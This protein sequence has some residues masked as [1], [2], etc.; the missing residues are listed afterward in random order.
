[1]YATDAELG[2]NRRALGRIGGVQ[3]RPLAL[4]QEREAKVEGV[5]PVREA[6]LLVGGLLLRHQLAVDPPLDAAR[7]TGITGGDR[8][9]PTVLGQ[10]PHLRL[11]HAG[12]LRRRPL[13]HIGR[14]SPTWLTLVGCGH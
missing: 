13:G 7:E 5:L 3:R 8:V 2:P 10:L 11:R 6:D 14:R 4:A 12:T 9:L 1:V